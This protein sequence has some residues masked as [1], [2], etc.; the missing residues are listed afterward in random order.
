MK[1]LFDRG[2]DRETDAYRHGLILGLRD[3]HDGQYDPS[4]VCLSDAELEGYRDALDDSDDPRDERPMRLIH[5]LDP[6]APF[7]VRVAC[8]ATDQHP[9]W[10]LWI[11]N[12]TCPDC[13]AIHDAARDADELPDTVRP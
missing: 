3:L 2:V 4:A 10:N 9:W 7:D 6:A 12:V 1:P 5:A 13:Q 8:N 11:K